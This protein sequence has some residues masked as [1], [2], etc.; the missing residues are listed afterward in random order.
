LQINHLTLL[1]PFCCVAQE[2]LQKRLQMKAELDR[3]NAAV[4]DTQTQLDAPPQQASSSLP[5]P[6]RARTDGGASG[7][8]A[9]SAGSSSSSGGSGAGD[10]IFH[11]NDNGSKRITVSAFNGKINVQ[12][13]EYYEDK[14]SG[15]WK[16]GKKGIALNLHEWHQL[17][18]HAT[19]AS[20][21][22][23]ENQPC[24]IDLGRKRWL[25]VSEFQK[26]FSVDVREYYEDKKTGESKPGIKGLRLSGELWTSCLDHFGNVEAHIEVLENGGT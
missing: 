23:Q 20:T 12:L 2:G 3:L 17:K 19:Q 10:G 26:I 15:E 5:P 16:P 4:V 11:I 7:T 6:K 9:S 22:L 14:S 8:G 1:H 18:K 21:S 25:S 24:K 13:R